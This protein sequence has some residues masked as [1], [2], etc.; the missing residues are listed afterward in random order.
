LTRIS[1][2]DNSGTIDRGELDQALQSFGYPLPR[3]LV[4][5][6]EKRFGK[7]HIVF[8][9]LCRPPNPADRSP[10]HSSTAPPKES[11]GSVP[12][13]I[14]FDRFLMACVTVKHFT[15]AFRRRDVRNEGRL[16]IDYNTFVSDEIPVHY[17][18]H[19]PELI[20]LPLSQ[21]DLVI[22]APV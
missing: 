7:R 18:L 2:R 22:D 4:R 14:T 17:A 1:G 19:V 10:F 5:K 12:R 8:V 9:S 16:T 11:E 15:E 6:L 13:G 3:D 21:M 20:P